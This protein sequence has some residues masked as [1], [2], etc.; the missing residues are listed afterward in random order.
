MNVMGDRKIEI[1]FIELFVINF[2]VYMIY[3][4][5]IDNSKTSVKKRIGIT[6]INVC[7]TAIGTYL[8]FYGDTYINLILTG[9]IY[10]IAIGIISKNKIGYSLIATIIAYAI[11]VVCLLISTAISFFII[12]QFIGQKSPYLGL[13][14]ILTVQF[15]ILNGIMGIKRLKNGLT[16]MKNKLDN[17]PIDILIIDICA[18][19]ILIYCLVGSMTRETI[20]NI[21]M[22]LIGLGITMVIVIHKSFTMYY[23]QKLM[24]DTIKQYE[25]DIHDK[26]EEIEKLS[27]EKY[28]ISR[29][30]HEFY[31]RQ[32]ALELK[33]NEMTTDKSEILCRIENLS[34]EYSNSLQDIKS[35][36]K[37]PL[38]NIPE[39]DD[40]FKYMRQECVKNNID[41]K[42]KLE[43]DI[44]HLVNKIIPINKLETLIGDHI[45][46]AI[47]AVN[48]SDNPYKSILVIIGRK[49]KN[50]E[51]CI[52]DSGIEFE[53][54][55]LEKLGK[56][57]VTTHE[58]TGGSGIGFMTTFATL[59]ECK[60]S[61]I[62]KEKHEM[63][64]NDYTKAVIIK[65][66]GKNEY[67]VSSYREEK[68]KI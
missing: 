60:A 14:C 63:K 24:T 22:A 43:T 47:I 3:N 40:M 62:I 55:T 45:R 49:N 35:I 61:L 29:I 28:E 27:K 17:E 26:D 51:L 64:N 5:L 53:I 54:E 10:G 4:K 12:Y 68:I 7:V 6:I 15:I 9:F 59:K 16:F 36:E 39:I 52:Y 23:K 18:I 57:R 31:N 58:K 1:Y 38:T 50:Y 44:H 41:F 67:K 37:L 65:F 25:K 32:K 8:E 13:A 19:V 48:S 33:V 11:C 30:N 46:N 42:L 34:N 56:E 66:D 20:R 21:Y 2:F